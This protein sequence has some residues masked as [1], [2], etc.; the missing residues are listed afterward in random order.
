LVIPLFSLYETAE[1]PLLTDLSKFLADLAYSSTR[2][3]DL[4]IRGR[5]FELVWSVFPRFDT[6]LLFAALIFRDEMPFE[7]SC[8]NGGFLDDEQTKYDETAR[9]FGFRGVVHFCVE[10]GAGA[11]FAAHWSSEFSRS[12]AALLRCVREFA[13]YPFAFESFAAVRELLPAAFAGNAEV[14]TLAVSAIGLFGSQ[15][16]AGVE[17]FVDQRSVVALYASP[18]DDRELVLAML[19]SLADG[20]MA[21][22]C[23]V[24]GLCYI[25][26]FEMFIRLIER[27]IASGEPPWQVAALRALA[28]PLQN[29]GSVLSGRGTVRSVQE[30]LQSDVSFR[31]KAEAMRALCH[32]FGGCNHEEKVRFACEGFLA[33][34]FAMFDPMLERIPNDVIDA[35][36]AVFAAGCDDRALAQWL[37]MTVGNPTI[38]A[39]LADYAAR[40]VGVADAPMDPATNAYALLDQLAHWTADG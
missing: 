19:R 24:N 39:A 9:S 25:E 36:R 21:A 8:P 27:G 26:L 29:A 34:L 1:P 28:H 3:A 5:H 30:L 22:V 35:V 11:L 4:F 32:F 10:S 2:Y 40:S 33:E 17:W 16:S 7:F 23:M 14:R 13:S 31:V 15:S 12:P 38:A 6:P 20:L 37:E 18:P